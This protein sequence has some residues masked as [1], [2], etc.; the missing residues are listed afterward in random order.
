M[1]QDCG[2][3]GV[4][5]FVDMTYV[6]GVTRCGGLFP[7]PRQTPF[8]LAVERSSYF[9]GARAERLISGELYNRGINVNMFAI[10]KNIN[11]HL[12][13]CLQCRPLPDFL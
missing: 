6:R 12:Q 2:L 1:F 13:L 5:Y 11:L 3:G 10:C 4:Q 8:P 9:P 7:L